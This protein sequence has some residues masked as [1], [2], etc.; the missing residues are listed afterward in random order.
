MVELNINLA[1]KDPQLRHHSQPQ[2]SQ[3]SIATVKKHEERAKADGTINNPKRKHPHH[4]AHPLC[5]FG[6]P[7]GRR[8]HHPRPR[9][10]L[11]QG[12]HRRIVRLPPLQGGR[13]PLHGRHGQEAPRG[14]PPVRRRERLHRLPRVPRRAGQDAPPQG[15][16]RTAGRAGQS[17]AREGHGGQ[18]D[19]QD[20]HDH[21]Q[22]V[23][24]RGHRRQGGRVRAVH[25]EHRHRGSVHAEVHGEEPRVHDHRHESRTVRRGQVVH[26]GARGDDARPEEEVR[27]EGVQPERRVRF[28]HRGLVHEG[29]GGGESRGDEGLQAGVPAQ[30][31]MQSPSEAGEHPLPSQH[32]PPLHGPQRHSRLH[33]PP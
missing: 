8:P 5:C 13:A 10:R 21:P 12:G 20:R 9:L 3:P 7:G 29:I 19:R 24:V 30:V 17:P 15:P 18:R 33:Q 4:G 31:R 2:T 23:P 27:R 6:I 22:P 25:R 16:R 11:R 28:G 1:R 26:R 14:R 32:R